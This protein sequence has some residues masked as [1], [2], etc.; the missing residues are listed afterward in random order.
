[1]C[2]I[3]VC[4]STLQTGCFLR[5]ER[6]ETLTCEAASTPTP[7]PTPPPPTS[8]PTSLPVE[9]T[10]TPTTV[11]VTDAN[12]ETAPGASRLIEG[13]GFVY[14]PA[15]EFTMGSD[16]AEIDF[17]LEICNQFRD[18]DCQRDWFADETP[19]HQVYLDGY[20]VM[21]T[22]VTNAHFRAF[23]DGEGYTTQRYWSSEGWNWRSDNSI[24]QPRYWTKNDFNGAQQPVVGVSW[25][26]AVA[27]ANWLSEKTGLSLRLPT[28]AEW[29]K[30]ARGTDGRIYP[31]GNEWS[32]SLVNS[33]VSGDGYELTAPVGSYPAGASPY[34]AYDM[35]GNVWEWTQTQWSYSYPYT[36]ND[37]READGGIGGR[38]LRGGSFIGSRNYVR[39]AYRFGD[40]PG[41]R[42]RHLGFRLLSP[43]S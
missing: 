15:G 41:D 12:G 27:Y 10:A 3:V 28:E 17:A 6:R 24:T 14:V 4:W 30:A 35:A 36:S 7:T 20:W 18:N 9:P 32:A 2:A 31:W 16:S 29:E 38:V 22:E 5:I 13:I 34:G 40:S 21:K 1:M 23:V 33:G 43:G 37:G 11:P 19:Q 25:Y 39:C 26:E 42:G 8:T